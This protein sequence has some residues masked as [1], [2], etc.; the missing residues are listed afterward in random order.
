MDNKSETS[1]GGKNNGCSIL[2]T[3]SKKVRLEH[4]SRSLSEY[5]IEEPAIY[6]ISL[7]FPR[8]LSIPQEDRP[9]GTHP[10]HPFQW[11][12]RVINPYSGFVARNTQRT[13]V[14]RLTMV[15]QVAKKG[16]VEEGR[17]I[18]TAPRLLQQLGITGWK[19]KRHDSAHS[20]SSQTHQSALEH[21]GYSGYLLECR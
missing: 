19:R 5:T 14:G 18:E 12:R 17:N 2:P 20:P 3:T 13:R 21:S 1:K 7:L 4:S 6:A 11:K 10:Q 9:I 15:D 16:G 8:K